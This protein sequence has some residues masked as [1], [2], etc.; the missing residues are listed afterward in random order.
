M[1]E[2]TPAKVGV[3]YI[4]LDKPINA[5][6]MKIVE[7]RCNQAIQDAIP[8]QVLMYQ[9]GDPEL[10]EAHTRGLPADHA[11]P[12]RLVK[13]GD[14]D[15]NLCCGTHVANLSHLQAIKLMHTESKKGKYYLYFLVGSRVL[16]YLTQTVERERAMTVVLR[17]GPEDH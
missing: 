4:E 16:K 10:N 5:D 11:G 3:S 14:V 17:N 12:I 9:M 7:D 1:A 2:S 6:T 8:V 15:S 13:I